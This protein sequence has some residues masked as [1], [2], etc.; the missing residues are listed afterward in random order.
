MKRFK[1]VIKR[2]VNHYGALKSSALERKRVDRRR[3]VSIMVGVD[4]S[5]WS[6][7]AVW[8]DNKYDVLRP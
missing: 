5:L 4:P 7:F 6:G 8:C 1:A 3:L 2:V